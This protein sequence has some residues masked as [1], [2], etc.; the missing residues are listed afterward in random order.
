[1]H[2][3]SS[4]LGC[5]NDETITGVRVVRI[6]DDGGRDRAA[7]SPVIPLLCG[8]KAGTSAALER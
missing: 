7:G 1:M 3:F 5:L 2:N 4:F 6:T 8:D